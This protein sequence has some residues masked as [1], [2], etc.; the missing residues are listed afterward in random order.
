MGDKNPKSKARDQKRKVDDK[1]ESDRK[2]QEIK[3]AKSKGS[4][5]T[6]K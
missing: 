2:A 3:D 6:K 1:T 4:K 5:D